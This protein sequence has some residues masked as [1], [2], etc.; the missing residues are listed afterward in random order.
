MV[1]AR[2]TNRVTANRTI[3]RI[4]AVLSGIV[5]VG[6][7]GCQIGIS[8]HTYINHNGFG[9]FTLLAFYKS[10]IAHSRRKNLEA[11][12]RDGASVSRVEKVIFDINNQLKPIMTEPPQ[13]PLEWRK[14]SF[15][16]MHTDF[17]LASIAGSV[18]WRRRGCCSCCCFGKPRR[19]VPKR[20]LQRD[21]LLTA[22]SLY[23]QSPSKAIT[24]RGSTQK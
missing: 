6:C 22:S 23:G 8:I 3:T 21:Q 17:S 18:Q 2:T 11:T 14:E 9:D 12:V 13:T 19:D 5:V 24:Q 1:P 4:S 7:N 20:W 16:L 10:C 15:S